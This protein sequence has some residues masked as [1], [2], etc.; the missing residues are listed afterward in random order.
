[1]TLEDGT[2]L[3]RYSPDHRLGPLGSPGARQHSTLYRHLEHI[4]SGK[5]SLAYARDPLSR[6]FTLPYSLSSCSSVYRS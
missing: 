5:E 2:Y 1:M 4:Q 6:H 3:S